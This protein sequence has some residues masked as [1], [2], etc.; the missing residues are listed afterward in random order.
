M[1]AKKVAGR[2]GP[3][4]RGEMDPETRAA[5]AAA[6]ANALFIFLLSKRDHKK[7]PAQVEPYAHSQLVIRLCCDFSNARTA[8]LILPARVLRRSAALCASVATT[9]E[10]THETF[11]PRFV[12]SL[13]RCRAAQGK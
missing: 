3:G 13:V 1:H 8:L 10:F 9:F 11:F 7:C 6:A 2:Q 4:W 12:V 5:A